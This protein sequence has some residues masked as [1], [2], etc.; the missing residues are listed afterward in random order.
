MDF[1]VYGN[2]KQVEDAYVY[3]EDGVFKM[4]M[5]DMGYFGHEAGLIVESKDGINW[6]EPQ[7]AWFGAD[8]YLEEPPAPRHLKRYGRMER[9][10]LLMKDGK[11]AYL[12]T[13]MQGGKYDTASGF[14][15]KI[16]E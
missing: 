11:P 1:S 7:I 14:V 2:D 16:N 12:F 9:P 4:L 3:M 6:S 13:A 5:R 15:F 8:A 10:Q